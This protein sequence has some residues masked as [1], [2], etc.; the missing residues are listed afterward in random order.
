VKY[1]LI[2][3]SGFIGNHFINKIKNDIIF[4]LDLD[5]G[6]NQINFTSCD[7]LNIDNLNK[8]DVS[9]Y[10]DITVIHLAAVHFD[11]QKYFYETNVEGTKNV[12]DFISKNDN[13]KCYVF[14]SSVATY[15]NSNYGKDENSKQEP[16]NDYGKSKLLAE[17]LI[18]SWHVKNQNVK[19]IIVRPAVVFGEY[20]FGNVFNLIN[21]IRNGLFAVIGN[22]M[23]I[24]SIAYAGNLVDSVMYCINNIKENQFIYNY[25][26]YPQEN[27]NSQS[28]II[29]KILGKS[30]P[31]KIPLW[32]TK[33][34]TLPIDLIEKLTGTDLKINS[35][36]VKKFTTPTFFLSDKI[37]S[38][39]YVQN[40]SI[41]DAY[42][43][44]IKWIQNN[45]VTKLRS[46][47]YNKA[48]K[49]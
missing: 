43:K 16:V 47:W 30:R 21:Q 39:G 2:G 4:N 38:H 17:G 37:R 23:N 44:T 45:D 29:S 41:N 18:K 24:K 31:Y 14:F 19:L 28:L 26:D 49:L 42:E 1:I 15:G 34:F 3:G 11:F 36:R 27:I 35:M 32:F 40:V 10:N 25:C 13:I 12:L 46:I 20:N 7:I 5:A 9:Q 33:I 48:S 8:I 22:G 6:I